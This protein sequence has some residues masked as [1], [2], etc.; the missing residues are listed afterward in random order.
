MGLDEMSDNFVF[1]FIEFDSPEIID[2]VE[3]N[4]LAFYS[5]AIPPIIFDRID[6]DAIH[7]GYF[8]TFDPVYEK[9][10]QVCS[11]VLG[12]ENIDWLISMGFDELYTGQNGEEE[13]HFLLDVRLKNKADMIQ[14]KLAWDGFNI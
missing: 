7:D 12:E 4:A 10:K 1:D 2:G 8:S 5:E 11:D 13:L 14:F 6:F 3:F 9:V